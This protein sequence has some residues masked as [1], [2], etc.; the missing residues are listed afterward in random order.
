MGSGRG[1]EGEGEV[2]GD[3]QVWD[4][5]YWLENTSFGGLR[6]SGELSFDQ[7]SPSLGFPMGALLSS[8]SVVVKLI[9]RV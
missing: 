4:L 3:D 8:V 5:Q 9:D 1:R 7:I 6:S 2:K